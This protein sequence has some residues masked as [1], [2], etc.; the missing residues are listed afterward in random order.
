LTLTELLEKELAP[1]VDATKRASK[2]SAVVTPGSARG[3]GRRP[4]DHKV[5]EQLQGSQR[6]T[7]LIKNLALTKEGH[8]QVIVRQLVVIKK[9]TEKLN[10]DDALINRIDNDKT[11]I[12]V[13]EIFRGGLSRKAFVDRLLKSNEVSKEVSKSGSLFT[14]GAEK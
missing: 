12:D 6:P 7:T 1:V 4:Q 9:L 10:R 8:Q 5:V 13:L 14:R 11:A 3:S 2:K